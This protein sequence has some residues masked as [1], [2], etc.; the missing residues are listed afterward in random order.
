MAGVEG[1]LT[2]RLSTIL[3]HSAPRWLPYPH[4]KQYLDCRSFFFTEVLF[5]I[6]SS[7]WQ[8]FLF[9]AAMLSSVTAP[10]ATA[11]VG[12]FVGSSGLA[13]K[14]DAARAWRLPVYPITA[15]SWTT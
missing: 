6:S 8:S 12:S 5:L 1:A 3:L 13:S 4:L 11:G 14:A 10:P 2:M 9:F 15:A 7:S